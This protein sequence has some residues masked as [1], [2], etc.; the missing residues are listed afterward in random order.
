M[1]RA[2]NFFSGELLDFLEVVPI[3]LLENFQTFLGFF[4]SVLFLYIFFPHVFLYYI[5]SSPIIVFSI[6][7]IRFYLKTKYPESQKLKKEGSGE[8]LSANG[9]LVNKSNNPFLRHQK[10]VRRNARKEVVE[11]DGKNR[12]EKDV[13]SS[14]TDFLEEDS[15]LIFDRLGIS[16]VE[17]GDCSHYDGIGTDR[18]LG[19]PYTVFVNKTSKPRSAWGDTF[20]GSLGTGPGDGGVD[21]KLVVKKP[22]EACEASN[23]AKQG[24]QKNY[25]DLGLTEFEREKRLQNLIT[26]RRTKRLFRM[27]I[28]KS[29][30]G[31]HNAPPAQLA[32][33]RID[34]HNNSGV[35]SNLDE[36][37][38]PMPGSAPPVFLP[39]RNSFDLRYDPQEEKPNLTADTFQQEFMTANQ[40]EMFFCRHES[41]HRGP[42]FPYPTTQNPNDAEFNLYYSDEKRLVEGKSGHHRLSSSGVENDIAIVEQEERNH[43]EAINLSKERKEQ[44]IE[45]LNNRTEIEEKIEK[46][47]EL[48]PGLDSGSEVRMET[49]SIRNNDSCYSSSSENTEPVLDQTIKTSRIRNDHVQRTL[50]LA[51]PPKG[52]AMNR[53][54]FD[55]SPSP[56]ERRKKDFNSFY[57]RRQCHTPTFS[58]AS[59]LQ[60]E[61]SEVGS[62]PLTTD[63][64]VSSGDGDSVMYD[65]DVDRDINSENEEPWGGRFNLSKEEVNRERLGELNDIIEE[66]SVEVASISPSD[67]EAKKSLNGTSSPSSGIDITENGASHPTYIN[68]EAHQCSGKC[69]HGNLET[70]Y[71]ATST[72]ESGK[73][74]EESQPSKYIEEDTRTLTEHN[75]RDTPSTVRSRGN[76]K[77]VPDTKVD[78]DAAENNILERRLR[79]SIARA[80]NRRLMLEKVSVSSSSSPRSVLQK[81][82]LASPVPIS[83]GGRQMQRSLS[84]YV[85]EDR[86]RSN[87]AYE[88]AHENLTANMPCVA[89]ELVENSMNQ[90]TRNRSLGTLEMGP[91]N[92]IEESN[93]VI[94]INNSEGIGK[95]K[96]GELTANEGESLFLIRP[97]DISGSEK[98][99]EQEVD[100]NETETIESDYTRIVGSE[101][102]SESIL[103]VKPK[104]ISEPEKSNEQEADMNETETIEYT[105]IV[106]SAKERE[107]SA[108]KVDR[109]CKANE[110]VVDNVTNKEIKNEVLEREGALQILGKLEAVIET[111]N[112]TEETS[113]GSVEDIEQESKRLAKAEANAGQSTSAGETNSLNNINNDAKMQNLT[114]QEGFMDT[115]ESGED[116][117][118]VIESVLRVDSI[119]KGVSIDH[120]ISVKVSKLMESEVKAAKMIKHDTRIDPSESEKDNAKSDDTET[121]ELTNYLR[122]IIKEGNIFTTISDLE[123]IDK[124]GEKFTA[125]KGGS[126]FS[127]RQEGIEG[128]ERLNEMEADVKKPEAIE[129]DYTSIVETAIERQNSAA[130]VDR[131]CKANESVADNVTNKEIK[132]DVLE[133]EGALRILG[134]LESFIE[135][136]NITGETSEGSVEDTEHKS[137]RLAEAEAN[138]SLSTSAGETNSSNNIKNGQEIQNMTLQEGMEDASQ[139]ME[140][141]LNSI[142]NIPIVDNITHGTSI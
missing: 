114:G 35:S 55:S 15:E 75:T 139:S 13:F 90:L 110:P 142:D 10:S 135:P 120:D 136:S 29:L 74:V 31:I 30:M 85:R 70:S 60:V 72:K 96:G 140:G 117:L 89:H 44:I 65:E 97:E 33:I 61:V 7:Y 108:A 81:N 126:R 79:D 47:H 39:K 68:C 82:I 128:F 9:K 51:I 124:E 112:T 6:I 17:H 119:T 73:E 83:G 18:A 103:L 84:H 127:I 100:M 8:R 91:W 20:Q 28:E 49:D 5:Y 69:R 11:W 50:K 99:N 101:K 123:V 56:S 118:K 21:G 94:N 1:Q 129:N 25:M 22:E 133:R 122:K 138:S 46:P 93:T 115:S 95:E 88:Q 78:Q 105:S 111:S 109:I 19:D 57:I 130:E 116:D 53:L 34:K 24:D 137:K 43:N 38:S 77:S 71:E 76:L 134:R 64:T 14:K 36:D 59:D 141:N 48:E 113:A 92:I 37:E 26:K 107:N 45:S 63:G 87:L 132:E 125:N 41:F 104:D 54:S 32:A 66:E 58:I 98:S 40:K 62:P 16:S 2:F 102:E 23:R 121:M 4:I 3:D 67:H 80:L 12:E 42:W 52:R 106:E 27:A 131:I 86:V